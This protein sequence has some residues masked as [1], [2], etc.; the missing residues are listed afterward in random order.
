M[1]LCVISQNKT[2]EDLRCPILNISDVYSAFL[3][4]VEE[5]RKLE[6][7]PVKINFNNQGTVQ[8][9][10]DNNAAWHKQCHQK[11]N[12]SKLKR[13]QLKNASESVD[14]DDTICYDSQAKRS[15]SSSESQDVCLFM[16]M[17]RSLSIFMTLLRSIQMCQLM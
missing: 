17:I 16:M 12:N 9:F 10:V 15:K 5:F 6:C 3:N 14:E 11:F 13:M 1:S 4:N 2:S 7:L 8:N